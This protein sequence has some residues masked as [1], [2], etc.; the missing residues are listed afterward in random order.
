MAEFECSNDVRRV[1]WSKYDRSTA[2]G[3]SRQGHLGRKDGFHVSRKEVDFT[4][5]EGKREIE[6]FNVFPFFYLK[7]LLF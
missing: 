3:E 5:E 6:R 7:K 1:S 2:F 4:F